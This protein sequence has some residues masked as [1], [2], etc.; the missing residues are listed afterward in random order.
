MQATIAKAIDSGIGLDSIVLGSQLL[1]RATQFFDMPI[2]NIIK[3][4][5]AN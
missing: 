2:I 3:N 4:I 5:E 1:K